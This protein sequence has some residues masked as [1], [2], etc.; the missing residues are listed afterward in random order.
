MEQTSEQ[1]YKRD[2]W[3][4]ENLNY[5]KPHFRLEKSARIVNAIAG[6]KEADLLDVG[7]GPATLK[8][9]LAPN[10]NYHGLDIAIHN[11]A[12]YLLQTDF[13]ETPI[14]F[15]DKRFDIILAQGVFEYIGT[16]QSEKFSE[17]QRLLKKD[18]IFVLSY[19][20]FNHIHRDVYR[21]YN[22]VQSFGDF[23]KSLERFF[24][25]DRFLPTSHHWH[26]HEPNR[27]FMKAIQ[28]HINMNIPLLSPLFAVEYFFVCSPRVQGQ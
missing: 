20:N 5:V 24:N 4:R 17:I 27:K 11:P 18:G 22:N 19:V 25:V 14:R 8:H 2:F 15:G 16:H 23:K 26:H 9:L 12:P 1:Y 6:G 13:L 3:V 21:I 28:M 10:V 7:C